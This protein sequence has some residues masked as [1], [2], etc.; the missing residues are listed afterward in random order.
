MSTAALRE[1]DTQPARVLPL[2]IPLNT[3]ILLGFMCIAAPLP[4]LPLITHRII[5][6]SAIISGLMVGT[7][8][9]ST[10]V[11]RRY[12]GHVADRLGPTW[13]T[14]R[15]LL[16]CALSGLSYI[17]VVPLLSHPTIVFGVLLF[18][19]V[20]LGLGESLILT[21]AI[22]WGI[23]RVGAQYSGTVMSWN[24]VAMYG[25]LAIGAPL[26]L[27]VF[28]A[29]ASLPLSLMLLGTILVL[30]PLI[31]LGIANRVPAARSEHASVADVSFR[32]VL[33]KIWP[34]G[35]ALTFQMVGYGT[36]ISFLTLAYATR[37][38]SG[39]GIAFTCF[40]AAVIGVRLAFG[41][42]P[43]RIGGRKVALISLCLSCAGQIIL[44]KA[45]IPNV[46]I[47]GTVL[48]GMGVAL[49]F[50]AL[51]IEAIRRVPPSNR[52]LVIAIFSAFQDLA[53][54]L[55]GPA[56]GALVVDNR[57]QTVFAAGA[58]AAIIA[59]LLILH[60]ARKVTSP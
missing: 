15:G 37:H 7:Q 59:A 48:T 31:A 43:D 50:P 16:I 28:G 17:S 35:C 58:T 51:G 60:A 25:A 8:S 39:A 55:T 9:L 34:F 56:T 33:Q 12:A 20:I 4:V 27:Y 57:Y 54:G 10:V 49:G 44:W 52:G 2:L 1:T 47:A 21:G 13:A 30:L 5:S 42:L 29:S 40:G 26:G 3:I 23:S 6:F 14:H 36:I 45:P 11:S 53:F 46:M 41:G 22:T 38:W 32:G 19:R 18:G 24:G